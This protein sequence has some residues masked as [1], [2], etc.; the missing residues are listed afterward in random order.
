MVVNE[1]ACLLAKRGA[2]ESIASELA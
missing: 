2:L 1:N